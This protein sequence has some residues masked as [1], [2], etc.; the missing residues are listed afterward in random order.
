MDVNANFRPNG[1]LQLGTYLQTGTLID[2]AASR[3]GRR[4]MVEFWGDANIGRGVSVNLSVNHQRMRRDG[5]TAFE[6]TVVNGGG[7]WQFDPRQRV[8]L[9][10]QGS[11]VIRDPSLYAFPVNQLARDWAAQMVY[12]YKVNPRT[13]IYA[14]GSYG[15]FMDDDNLD[16]FGNSRSLFVKL[17]YG[18]QP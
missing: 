9:T 16:M 8:R 1:A 4:T 7:S 3:T 13:A 15:A 18:W 12:S 11:E 6:A 10:L 5:G 17:S 14:G 2:L